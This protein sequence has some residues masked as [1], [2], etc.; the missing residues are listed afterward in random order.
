MSVVRKGEDGSDVYIFPVSPYGSNVVM[1]CA[2][3]LL[4]DF[5]AHQADVPEMIAHMREHRAVG[6]HVPDWVEDEMRE[7]QSRRPFL[8]TLLAGPFEVHISYE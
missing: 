6:H 3:C 2:H 8:E 1:E 7:R 4:A 5:G